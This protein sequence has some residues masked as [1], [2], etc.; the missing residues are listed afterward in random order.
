[1][2][3]GRRSAVALRH[4]V[5]ASFADEMPIGNTQRTSMLGSVPKDDQQANAYLTAQHTSHS[6]VV[7]GFDPTGQRWATVRI[8]PQLM[9]ESRSIR[10]SSWPVSR[11]VMDTWFLAGTN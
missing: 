8:P 10:S 11:G 6:G 3:G 7:D 2:P 9:T 1:V 4:G 5:A